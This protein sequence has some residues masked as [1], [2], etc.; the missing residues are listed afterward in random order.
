M[1][2]KKPPFTRYSGNEQFAKQVERFGS[3]STIPFIHGVVR[4]ALANPFA[5]DPGAALEEVFMD[6]DI[7]GQSHR[8][9]E[10]LSLAFLYLWNDTARSLSSSRPFPEALS[11][12]IRT[13]EDEPAILSGAAD[14]AKGFIRGFR[15]KTPAKSQRFPCA[16]SWLK[17]IED[18]VGRRG[19]RAQILRFRSI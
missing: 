9:F 18:E 6:A 2:K 19:V 17:D 8:D 4:G 13:G 7:K 11:S 10:K 14:L 5:V 15:L 12:G 3:E 1:K 16:G